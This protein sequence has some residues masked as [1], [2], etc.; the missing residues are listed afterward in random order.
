MAKSVT[1]IDELQRYM[2]GVMARADHHAGEVNEIALA[3]A[4]AIVWKKDDQ[5][6]KVMSRDGE[7]KN[8]LWVNIGGNKYAFSYNHDTQNIEMRKGT[9]QGSVLHAFDNN[10]PL[11]DIRQIFDAL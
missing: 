5:T 10:T 6:I 11:S 3:L 7:T 9:I 1:D 8:V 2:L 4:G